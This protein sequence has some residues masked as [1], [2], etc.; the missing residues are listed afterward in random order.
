LN[1]SISH[2]RLD[3]SSASNHASAEFREDIPMG[4]RL[5]ALLQADDDQTLATATLEASHS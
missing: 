1:G 2:S 4:E 5:A 3:R